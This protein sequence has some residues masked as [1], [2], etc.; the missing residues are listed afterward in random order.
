MRPAPGVHTRRFDEELVILDLEHGEYLALDAIGT[1]L[2]EGLTEGKSIEELAADVASQYDVSL[3]RAK[4]D[5]E[6][7]ASEFVAKGL[8]IE[9]PAK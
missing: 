3:A 4:A 1:M 5:L 7:L 9:G 6:S 8:M 2:W